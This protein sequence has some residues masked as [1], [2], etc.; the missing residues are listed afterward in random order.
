MASRGVAT[1]AQAQHAGGAGLPLPRADGLALV[2][3]RVRA[4]VPSGP[5][6]GPSASNF[7]VAS[8]SLIA[9]RSEAR[10][11]IV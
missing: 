11:C 5:A 6:T 2:L 9:L 8:I 1:M 4:S 3:E 10:P 7:L